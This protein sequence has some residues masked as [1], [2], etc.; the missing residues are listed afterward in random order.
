MTAHE[1]AHELAAADLD[2]EL[3]PFER[4]ELDGHLSAC[5]ECRRF[6][7]GLRVDAQALTRLPQV[8]APDRV[9]RLVLSGHRRPARGR[10]TLLAATLG[11]AVVAV[12]FVVGSGR[13]PIGSSAGAAA[14]P[15]IAA[16]S[17]AAEG[18]FAPAATGPPASTGTE[19]SSPPG[20]QA[21]G[22][23]DVRVTSLRVRTKP[24][25]SAS[26]LRL[27]PFLSTPRQ[28]A[29]LGGPVTAD[30]Y[31]W[32][33]V[34]PVDLKSEFTPLNGSAD[35]RPWGWVATGSREGEPWIEPAEAQCPE[36]PTTMS[37]IAG[38]VGLTG[39][40][41]FAGESITVTATIE[42]NP[43]ADSFSAV[44]DP[45]WF[46]GGGPVFAPPLAGQECGYAPPIDP[47]VALPAG[48]LDA[49]Y[50][51]KVLVTGVFDHPAARDC[52][53]RPADGPVVKGPEGAIRCRMAFVVTVIETR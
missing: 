15:P 28:I 52:V 37:E 16:A 47:A 39:L 50:G 44:P 19:A 29:I 31:E 2:F 36:T 12:G 5:V 25:R 48:G 21:G 7:L 43:C 40:V 22:V 42:Q 51:K 53:Y 38:L 13:L 41:C 32:Y 35:P 8:D 3:A 1:R 6:A 18:S 4:A 26:S 10:L 24:D 49:L 11:T 46:L 17:T 9:T 23:A 14:S 27:V 45:R 30:D 33:F 34:A 20:L